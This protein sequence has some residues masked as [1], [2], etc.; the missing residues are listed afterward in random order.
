M[1]CADGIGNAA[2]RKHEAH[3]INWY[4]LCRICRSCIS[5]TVKQIINLCKTTVN[6]TWLACCVVL[7]A[8]DP[9]CTS[10]CDMSGAGYCD[11]MCN[12][13]YGLT[14]NYTCQRMFSLV[15]CFLSWRVDCCFKLDDLFWS[16]GSEFYQLAML[17]LNT[18]CTMMNTAQGGLSPCSLVDYCN[19]SAAHC[20]C[21]ITEIVLIGSACATVINCRATT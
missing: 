16:D 8:C 10:G 11:S 15:A 1:D 19:R 20:I 12:T 9:Q 4:N 13:T 18:A 6:P 5:S 3:N 7:A 21:G 17:S 2:C 14:A